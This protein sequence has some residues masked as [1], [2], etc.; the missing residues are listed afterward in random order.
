MTTKGQRELEL[1]GAKLRRSVI[2]LL[3][4]DQRQERICFRTHGAETQRG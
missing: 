3:T 1:S 2:A 4:H